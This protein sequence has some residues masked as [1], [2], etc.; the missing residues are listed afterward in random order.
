NV[1]PND[2]A[3]AM[4]RTKIASSSPEAIRELSIGKMNF[5]DARGLLILHPC[6]QE[7][8][9]LSP[10]AAPAGYAEREVEHL[11]LSELGSPYS[12]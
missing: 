10:G 1:R 9:L 6:L 8:T 7:E 2:R 11:T 5:H 4:W 3:K 12:V